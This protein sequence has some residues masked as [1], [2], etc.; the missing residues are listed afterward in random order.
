MRQ[1][2]DEETIARLPSFREL[3][4]L[5]TVEKT[6]LEYAELFAIDHLSIDDVFIER[7]RACLSD[8]EILDL[9]VCIGKYLAFGRISKVLGLD[10]VCAPPRRAVPVGS[11]AS[12]QQL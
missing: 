3:D 6:V 1:D 4:G 10:E 9:S 7:L 12:D 11:A 2:L 5:S 8:A